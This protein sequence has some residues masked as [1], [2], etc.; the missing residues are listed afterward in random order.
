MLS[1]LDIPREIRDEILCL[2]LSFPVNT[3]SNFIRDRYEDYDRWPSGSYIYIPST[4]VLLFPIQAL[5]L[6]YTCSQLNAETV[7]CIAK[8]RP[9]PTVDIAIIE[10]HW[11]WPTWRI[12]PPRT[13]S[14]LEK[15]TVNIYLAQTMEDDDSL[16][17]G[18]LGSNRALQS[19]ISRF[20]IFG[21][22]GD[23]KSTE[24]DLSIQV[25]EVTVDVKAPNRLSGKEIFSWDAIPFRKMHGMA[26]LTYDTLS[27]MPLEESFA[28]LDQFVK[29]LESH[30]SLHVRPSALSDALRP[31]YERI[32]RLTFCINGVERHEVELST[33]AGKSGTK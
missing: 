2:V 17:W 6:L 32:G 26:H 25:R 18:M 16:D 1:L 20:L 15:L 29:Y 10:K 4:D 33:L 24:E 5:S 14:L 28:W 27:P 23:R 12:M 11:L 3:T 30:P 31:F 9:P 13:I 19:F 22:V 8:G 21:A 7:H